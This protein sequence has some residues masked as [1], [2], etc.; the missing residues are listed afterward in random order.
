MREILATIGVILTLY[1]AIP[2]IID[3]AKKRTKPNIVSWG[4]WSML[5]GIGAAAAFAS[6]EYAAAALVGANALQTGS[7]VILGLR[8]GIA[9]MSW[10]DG[11]AQI[12]AIISLVLWLAY[13]S[14][15]FAIVGVVI[16]DFFG[17][18]P[19]VRH[20]W[21]HPEE[22]TWQSFA[23]AFIAPFFTLASLTQFSLENTLYPVYLGL[24]DGVVTAIIIY[25]RKQKNIPLTLKAPYKA[26]HE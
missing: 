8:N 3:V 12:G 10:F 15:A 14:P 21:R 9:K 11:F 22:E 2:Y 19:T 18:L 1:A 7:I 20:S 24:A 13:D 17:M 6:G 5:T 16:I 4:T 26:L 23:I 25:R